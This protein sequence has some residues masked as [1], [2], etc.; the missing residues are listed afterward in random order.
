MLYMQRSILF[1]GKRNYNNG[2]W[3]TGLP[4]YDSAGG[5]SNIC[6]WFGDEGAEAY[7][8]LGI[9]PK[10]L[11]QQI[12]LK[13]KHGKDIFEGD[14]LER[15][16]TK[17]HFTHIPEMDNITREL[18][19]VELKVFKDNFGVQSFGFSLNTQRTYSERS[20]P[21]TYEIIGNIH[22]NPEL[23]TTIPEEKTV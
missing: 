19:V 1:R 2:E 6:G 4:S 5:I 9:D 14:V 15:I 13:D 7:G 21:A 18:V 23:L 20:N 17:D 16:G 22:D 3:V 10:T 11:G 12:G 8:I